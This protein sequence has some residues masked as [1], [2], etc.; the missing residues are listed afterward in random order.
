MLY[1]N[2][3]QKELTLHGAFQVYFINLRTDF[4]NP[5]TVKL[6]RLIRRAGIETI[7]FADR[8]V[9]VKIHFGEPGNLSFLRPNFARAVADVIRA[10]GG[11]PFL[12]D[13]NT[14]Y[15]AGGKMRWTIWT[16]QRKTVFRSPRPAVR[17]SLRTVSRGSTRRLFPS[18]AASTLRK[19]RSGRRLWTPISSFP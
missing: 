7:D 12:T 11:R 4:D 15:T 9:A 1:D 16:R 3:S 5:L 8:F 2:H 6:Q 13:C 10:K 17:L 19:Q 18:R 14:L